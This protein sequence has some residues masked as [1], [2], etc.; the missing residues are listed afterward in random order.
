[1]PVQSLK[2]LYRLS[3]FMLVMVCYVHGDTPANCTY[4][5]IRGRWVFSIGEGGHDNKIDCSNLGPVKYSYSLTLDYPDNVIDE[6]GNKGFWTLIYNQGFEVV[7]HGRKF[8]AF[9]KFTGKDPNATSYC[10]ETMVGWSHD[11]LGR[12]W[13]CYAGKKQSTNN[14]LKFQPNSINKEVNHN[15]VKDQSQH[16]IYKVDRDMINEIN[17][18]QSLWTAVHYSEYEHM[19]WEEIRNMAGGKKSKIPQIPKPARPNEEIQKLA[20][21]LPDSFDWRNVSGVNFVSPVRNQGGCGSCYAFSSAGMN[22]A[23]LRVATNNRVQ[24]VFSPQD[25]VECSEYSQGCAGG[26]PYLIGG[27]Y[28]EDFGMVEEACNPY[29]DQRA[30]FIDQCHT[31]TSCVRHYFTHYEYIGGYYGACNEE[32]MRLALVNNGP[33]AVSFEVYDDFMNY[34]SGI[35]HHTGLHNRFNPFEITNHAVL[36]VGYGIQQTTNIKYWIIKNSWGDGWGEEGFFR[37]LR[38]TNECAIESIAVQSFAMF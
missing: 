14:H 24:L 17:S 18:A 34:K 25:I 38:G 12:D 8:F 29:S 27:K 13:A 21:T 20:A 26:F 1:M 33:L 30:S 31:N 35:Y 15:F 16:H 9:S 22:E 28:S 2:M 23:R 7:I 10:D 6:F 32:L 3:V 37:I 4:E 11:V 36:L 5:Q 19:T